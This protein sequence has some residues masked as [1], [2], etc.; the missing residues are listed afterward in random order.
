MPVATFT[1][2]GQSP[3]LQGFSLKVSP[4]ALTYYGDLSTNNANVFKRIGTGSKFGIGVGMMKQFSPFF[5]IQ[6]QFVTGSLY[7]S[8][9]DNTYF[10]G[11][12]TEFS[13]AAR[14]D[15]LKLVKD[16]SF[17]LSPYLSVGVGTFGYRSVRREIATNLVILPSFG[18]LEDGVTHSRKQTAMSMPITA[19][20]SYQVLPYL[21]IELEHSIR[22]TNTDLIDCFKGPSTA[23]DLYSL[24][25]LGLRFTIPVKNAQ[26]TSSSRDRKRVPLIKNKNDNEV[27][28]EE[29]P[30]ANI[31]IDCDIPETITAGQTFEVKLRINK[32]KFNG[33]AK[34]VQ[35]YPEGFTE[36]RDISK[37]ALFSFANQNVILNWEKM[38]VEPDINYSYR[39]KAGEKLSGNQ[40]ITGYLEYQ[41]PDG[42]KTVRF[43]VT[44]FVE[45]PVPPVE[46]EVSLN[47]VLKQYD[48]QGNAKAE[49]SGKANIRKS[50]PLQGIEFRIQCGAFRENSK[51]DV[52]LAA[53]YNITE[54]IQEES[55][56]GWYK[57]TVGSFRTYEEAVAYRDKFIKR[58][59]I[60]E[61][62]I[63]AYRDGHRLA[64]ISDAFKQ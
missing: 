17:W 57:Y 35:K 12:L 45:N 61:A 31:F 41:E 37:S 48:D 28:S 62:F 47:Q 43:N 26:G 55:I 20:V 27:V 25:S 3:G 15:P 63:V 32:G 49:T 51:A 39:M 22:L 33:P 59:G 52:Q 56:D 13:L 50:Q 16:R 6:A 5:A 8:A 21:Q 46:K 10:A 44:V 34:L 40:T 64:K 54:L 1:S 7:S 36:A 14:F 30:V 19:G 42:S 38:P 4:G 58:T 29:T 23:N 24:T 9:A 11:A 18:Y 53:K 60:V 2:R